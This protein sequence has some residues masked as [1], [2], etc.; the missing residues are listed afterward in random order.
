MADMKWG[1]LGDVPFELT[2]SPQYGSFR[3]SKNAD[4]TKHK[5]V[6]TRNANDELQGQKPLKEIAGLGLDTISFGCK[7]TT[8]MLQWLELTASQELLKN[9]A[10]Q[11]IP[12]VGT[13]PPLG[14]V[15]GLPLGTLQEDPRFYTDIVKF[16]TTFEEMLNGQGSYP[17]YVGESFK[18]M[19]TLNGLDFVE[20][21][22][23]NGIISYLEMDI[24]LEESYVLNDPYA[25][26]S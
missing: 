4:F 22:R 14:A 18:G 19:F 15:A 24:E 3:H 9:N 16:K 5:R 26:V 2:T 11:Y 7:L 17:L 25:W 12:G 13:T 21:H 10:V 1:T 6:I 20:K 23:T 8:T